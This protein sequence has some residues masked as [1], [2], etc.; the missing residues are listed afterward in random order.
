M[1]SS[2]CNLYVV[3]F[4]FMHSCLYLLIMSPWFRQAGDFKRLGMLVGMSLIQ[5]GS[6]L[7][8]LAPAMYDYICG[9]DV[10]SI[11]ATTG[12][13]PNAELK[14]TLERVCADYIP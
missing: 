9:K 7:P 2:K 10:C 14:A 12:E 5:G 13:I 8:F 6:G 11:V 1:S 4:S 3:L